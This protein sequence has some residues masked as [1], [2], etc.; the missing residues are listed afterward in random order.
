MARID[1]YRAAWFTDLG[2]G[3][4]FLRLDAD[5]QRELV[6]TNLG[7]FTAM[8]DFLRHEKPLYWSDSPEAVFSGAESI[9]KFDLD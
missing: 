6:F 4:I 7:D 1:A 8:L 2:R 5:E 3:K 9:G